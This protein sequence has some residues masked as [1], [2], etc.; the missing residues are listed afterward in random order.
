MGRGLRRLSVALVA[1]ALVL[2][3]AVV[4]FVRDPGPGPPLRAPAGEYVRSVP[5]DRAVL[6][7][8]GDGADGSDRAKAVAARIAAGRVDRFLY[9]GDVYGSAGIAGVLTADGSAEDFRERYHPV[10]GA[11]A[12]RTAPTPGNHEW[13]RREEGY[14]PYWTR[15]HGPPP[16]YY[17]FTAGGW[18]ILSLNSEAP[19]GAGSAQLAWLRDQLRAPGTCRLA[20]LHRPRFSAG[21]H[22]DHAELQPLWEALEGR[23]AIAVAGHDHNMQRLRPIGGVT[24]LVSGAGGHGL[25]EA[26]PDPRVAFSDDDTFGALRIDLRPGR[27]DLAFVASDGRVLDRHRVGCRRG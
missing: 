4:F 19:R 21:R 16:T 5:G 22:G 12:E 7:A 1:G 15:V 27:A 23:V 25:Y 14:E 13:A 3:A 2:V 20:F 26:E 11:L 18:R 24:P 8:V 10:Y 9:L 6:W 17:A